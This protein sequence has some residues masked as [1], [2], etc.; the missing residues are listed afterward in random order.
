MQQNRP[1]LPGS[2]N[3]PAQSHALVYSHVSVVDPVIRTFCDLVYVTLI[4]GPDWHLNEIFCRN[5]LYF[6][7]KARKIY[8]AVVFK[9]RLVSSVIV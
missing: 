6:P 5:R 1:P 2:V 8:S 3:L 4:G 7:L 9:K